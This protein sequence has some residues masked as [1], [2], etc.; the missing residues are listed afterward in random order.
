MTAETRAHLKA[1]VD[2][3]QRRRTA[4]TG[5]SC[6]SECGG[7]HSNV[8]RGCKRCHDRERLRRMRDAA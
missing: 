7:D 4:F 5:R 2:A 6:Y 1:L 8:T 3:E